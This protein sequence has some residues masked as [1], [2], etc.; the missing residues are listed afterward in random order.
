MD[1]VDLLIM[2]GYLCVLSVQLVVALN[3][4]KQNKELR[5]EVHYKQLEVNACLKT[6]RSLVDGIEELST[7][8]KELED[9][10]KELDDE[11]DVL[12][13]E[14]EKLHNETSV[15]ESFMADVYTTIYTEHQKKNKIK[16]LQ[17]KIKNKE[18][19]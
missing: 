19:K 5:K 4:I 16:N 17:R 11:N 1:F 2:V 8:N 6:M 15:L 7:A 9:E 10:N 14:I 12:F 13:E 3:L 18:N